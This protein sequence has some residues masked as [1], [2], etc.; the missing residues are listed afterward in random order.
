MF[1]NT[2][3]IKLKWRKIIIFFQN[4]K[5][6]KDKKR[7]EKKDLKLPVGWILG[8]KKT[9]QTKPNQTKTQ[10]SKTKPSKI[11]FCVKQCYQH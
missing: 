2:L 6:K 3:K 10:Q 4:M 8:G 11:S 7:K 9:N 1:L 5:K